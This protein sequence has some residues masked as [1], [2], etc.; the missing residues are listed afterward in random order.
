[1]ILWREEG[2]R[3]NLRVVQNWGGIDPCFVNFCKL[4]S[5]DQVAADELA[6][7]W[8]ASVFAYNI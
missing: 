5:V 4:C 2:F 8:L 7:F 1:M 6:H 3:K